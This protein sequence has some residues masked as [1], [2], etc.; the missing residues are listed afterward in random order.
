MDMARCVTEFE[1]QPRADGD[2]ALSKLIWSNTKGGFL[3]ASGGWTTKTDA[4][5]VFKDFDEALAAA[6]KFGLRDAELHYLFDQNG[7]SEYDF[8]IR[9]EVKDVVEPTDDEDVPVV[10]VSKD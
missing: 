7:P 8:R 1:K 9:L 3:T 10:D 5:A 4:A 2:K 6:R